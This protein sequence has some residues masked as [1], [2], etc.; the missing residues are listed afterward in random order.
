MEV[1]IFG[2]RE[3][4]N[5]MFEID[6][7]KFGTFVAMLRKEK[8]LTQKEM[9]KLLFI[10]DKAVSKWETA[11]SIPDT[12]LL[13]P[14]ADLLGVT[15]TE[16]LM[17]RRMEQNGTMDTTQVENVVKTAISYSDDKP[18][19]A[20][21][22]K[23]KWGRVFILAFLV[24]CLEILVCIV[25]GHVTIGLPLVVLLGMIFGGYFCFFAVVRLPDYYDENRINMYNDNG[26]FN[27]SFPGLVFNNNN[28]PY[29]LKA[30][31]IWTIAAM[32]GYPAI[33]FVMSFLLPGAWGVEMVVEMA[34]IFGGMFIPMYMAGK[35]YE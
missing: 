19:R 23:D 8:G 32:T 10:S 15:V 34:F 6:K 9:A 21:Q 13:I 24:S 2:R 14:L 25:S 26:F 5:I 31:R 7:Q 33:S 30:G 16:L 28:W 4:K 18:V 27:I 29:I 35:K 11:V 22:A 12:A 20:Y 1:R 3:W 17:C